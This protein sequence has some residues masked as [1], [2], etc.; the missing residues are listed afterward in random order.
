MRKFISNFKKKFKIWFE[1][2]SK[3]K[4]KCYKLKDFNSDFKTSQPDFKT[5]HSNFNLD[6]RSF[7]SDRNISKPNLKNS[8]PVPKWNSE[9]DSVFHPNVQKKPQRLKSQGFQFRF[10]RISFQFQKI[11]FQ[12]QFRSLKFQCGFQSFPFRSQNFPLGSQ[13]IKTRF[14]NLISIFKMEF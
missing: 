3:C 4:R 8:F 6:L 5:F 7:G 14:E 11:S 13:S 10:W 1:F 2:P 12:F 9:C